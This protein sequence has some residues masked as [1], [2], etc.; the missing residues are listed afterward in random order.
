MGPHRKARDDESLILERVPVKFIRLSCPSP[1]GLTC[2]S[3]FLRM[4]TECRVNPCIK[5]EDGN[6]VEQM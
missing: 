6:D 5:S 2:G 1:A 4:K 3:I